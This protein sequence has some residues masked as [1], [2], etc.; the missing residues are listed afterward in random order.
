MT[1]CPNGCGRPFLAEIGLVGRA[2][3]LYNLY[4]GASFVGDRLNKLYREM[5]SEDEIINSLTPILSDFAQNKEKDE[6]FGDFVIRNNYV[7]A[8]T[9]GKN[10]HH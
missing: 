1:G 8:T 9:K 10:F 4:L 2:P 3:G 6:H 7:K 5:L